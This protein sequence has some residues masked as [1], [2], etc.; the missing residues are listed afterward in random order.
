MKI[1]RPPKNEL[2]KSIQSYTNLPN[3]DRIP[4]M[5]VPEVYV[6]KLRIHSN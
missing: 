2:L 3:D 6:P 1:K 5:R 4:D